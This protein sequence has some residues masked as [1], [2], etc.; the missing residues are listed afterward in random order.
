VS[1]R[2]EKPWGH[3]EILEKTDKYVVKKLFVKP[4]RKLSYQYHENKLETMFL[5]SGDAILILDG[6]RYVMY[7]WESIT[8]WPG[9][10]HRIDSVE[11]NRE[12]A[13]ILEVSTTE[14]DDVVRL[15]DDYGRTE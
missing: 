15:E 12:G 10:K 7:P 13:C 2:I 4:G 1:E 9:I 14:L 3:E 8:I 6:I 11:S 5:L